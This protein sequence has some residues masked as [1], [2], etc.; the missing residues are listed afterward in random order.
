MSWRELSATLNVPAHWVRGA[1]MHDISVTTAVRN[2][3]KWTHYTGLDPEVREPNYGINPL[4]GV[5][6]AGGDVRIVAGRA[7]PLARTWL[8]RVNAGL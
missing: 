3:D 7:V 5:G 8:I 1:R 4:T 2:L 6:R